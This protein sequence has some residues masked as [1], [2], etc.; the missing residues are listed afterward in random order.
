[1]QS[2]KATGGEAR[3]FCHAIWEGFSRCRSLD[4]LS[5]FWFAHIGFS[6]G[7]TQ[8]QGWANL[9]RCKWGT[10]PSL[11]HHLGPLL[12]LEF[13]TAEWVNLLLFPSSVFFFGW[14]ALSQISLYSKHPWEFYV[15]SSLKV[16][17]Q[18]SQQ[19]CCFS[20]MVC[21]PV[22]SQQKCTS[23]QDCRSQEVQ[24]ASFMAS[25]HHFWHVLGAC[26]V[27]LTAM[28]LGFCTQFLT[29]LSVWQG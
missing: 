28:A 12:L 10:A 24:R 5:R 16:V 22:Q 13:C 6:C 21:V 11:I 15:H 8:Q 29:V 25:F 18:S 9:Q 1:M 2:L 4:G 26:P 20:E 3:K 7:F 17:V 14:I 19:T 23:V 27:V